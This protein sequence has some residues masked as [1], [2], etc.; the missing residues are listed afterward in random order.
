[1]PPKIIDAGS[2]EFRRLKALA[3]LFQKGWAILHPITGQQRE[4]IDQAF[5]KKLQGTRRTNTKTELPT[6]KRTQHR[7]LGARRSKS[8]GPTQSQ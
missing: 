4:F 6:Q 5:A 1:M 2:E 8:K 3:P 7:V